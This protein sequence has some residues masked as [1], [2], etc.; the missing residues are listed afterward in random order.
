[1][2]AFFPDADHIGCSYVA[3]TVCLMIGDTTKRPDDDPTSE[4]EAPDFDGTSTDAL[5]DTYRFRVVA[6]SENGAIEHDERGQA[7]WK[8]IT[9]TGT[10]QVDETFDQVKALD[11]PELSLNDEAAPKPEPPTKAGYD[12]YATG[13]FEKPKIRR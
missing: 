10:F 6:A 13:V 1:M 12:P 4:E 8:W 2:R 7:R 3:R 5:D 9:E 11:N